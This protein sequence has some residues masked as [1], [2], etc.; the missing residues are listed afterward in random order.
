[1]P[2]E[3]ERPLGCGA[4]DR[5]EVRREKQYGVRHAA[6]SYAARALILAGS[7]LAVRL[8]VL[9]AR[10]LGEDFGFRN[11]SP[12]LEDALASMPGA[13]L[14]MPPPL[15]TGTLN[16]SRPAWLAAIKTVRC[17]DVVYWNQPAN[18]P[19]LRLW[20]L[21]YA[22]RRVPKVC[23]SL[24]PSQ[25]V[26]ERLRVLV[27]VQRV[28]LCF[29]TYREAVE[30]IKQ[31]S[32]ELPVEWLPCGF[33]RTAFQ[34]RGLPRDIDVLWIGRR[35]PPLHA[36][37]LRFSDETGYVYRYSHHSRE[38]ATT[39]EVSELVARARYFVVTPPGPDKRVGTFNPLT[40]RYFEGLAAG[41]RLLGVL[42]RSGEF[43]DVFPMEAIVECASDGSDLSA[44]LTAADADPEWE[45]KRVRTRDLVRER[46]GWD[47]RARRI[48][49]RITSLQSSN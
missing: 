34:D 6:G 32:P 37:L 40:T 12:P 42:P 2:H 30:A 25:L 10:H 3:V 49:S 26:L 14:V 21:A 31:R 11:T 38:P 29:V 46:H 18:H 35:H 19:D 28:A 48:Y 36:A 7:W 16:G 17:A 44:V 4:S 5:R 22:R 23:F 41:A 43:Q 27:K 1:V 15:R 8:V 20:A 47:D 24:D 33:S 9:S 13:T 39:E 45:A